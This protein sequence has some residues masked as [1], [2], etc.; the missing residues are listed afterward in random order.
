M[1]QYLHTVAD[2]VMAMWH[3]PRLPSKGT[4][5]GGNTRSEFNVTQ[6]AVLDRTVFGPQPLG[7]LNEYTNFFLCICLPPEFQTRR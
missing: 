3:I 2:V 1:S 6:S 7:F 5:G 4:V